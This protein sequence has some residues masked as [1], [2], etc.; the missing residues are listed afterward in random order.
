MAEAIGRRGGA[1]GAHQERGRGLRERPHQDGRHGGDGR[2]DPALGYARR[3]QRPAAAPW[4]A[5]GGDPE[6]AAA[7]AQGARRAPARGRSRLAGDFLVGAGLDP[8]ALW[9]PPA[10]RLGVVAVV[11]DPR[12]AARIRVDRGARG[13]ADV[14]GDHRAVDLAGAGA[15]VGHVVEHID[16]AVHVEVAGDRERARYDDPAAEVTARIGLRI[17]VDVDAGKV[18]ERRG[19]RA[20]L[21]DVLAAHGVDVDDAVRYL[22]PGI[23]GLVALVVGAI[24]LGQ[25]L[26]HAEL[27]I[28]IGEGIEYRLRHVHERV[29]GLVPR[30]VAIRSVDRA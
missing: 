4:A 24:G 17:A 6:A 8:E 20:I 1:R 21:V 28:R 18:R 22:M 14:L 7:P 3:G 15:R 11:I 16:H 19:I 25:R 5:Y 2:A 13:V 23:E 9:D 12:V 10:A 27:G 26:Q 30:I 29:G